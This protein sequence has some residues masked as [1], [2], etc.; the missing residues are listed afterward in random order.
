MSFTNYYKYTIYTS[1][2]TDVQQKNKYN[3]LLCLKHKG[4]KRICTL[5][6][7]MCVCELKK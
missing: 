1:K 2:L 7:C 6:V 4:Y 3:I 5:L